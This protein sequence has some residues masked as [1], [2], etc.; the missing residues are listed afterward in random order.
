MKNVFIFIIFIINI[1]SFSS[2]MNKVCASLDIF[3]SLEIMVPSIIIFSTQLG[4]S[5]AVLDKWG[6]MRR[7]RKAKKTDGCEQGDGSREP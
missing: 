4:A 2:L 5:L 1:M 6:H 3:E 7:D